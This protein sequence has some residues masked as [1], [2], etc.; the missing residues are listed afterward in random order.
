MLKENKRNEKEFATFMKEAGLIWG[1]S[2]EIYGGL[3]GFYTYG[4]LGKLLKNKVENSVRKVFNG[5][6]LREIE[7]PT[8]LPDKVWEISGHLETFKDNIIKCSNCRS[9]FR[10]DKI[11]EEKYDVAA[12]AFSEERLL[13]FIEE[14]EI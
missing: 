7:G 2:P 1:P 3:S 8:V 9:V 14:K 6:G 5:N 4:P 13:K 12:D 11:I 10:P